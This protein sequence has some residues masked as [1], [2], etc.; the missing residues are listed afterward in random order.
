MSLVTDP[1]DLLLDKNNDLIVTTDLVFGRGVPAV[2]QSC[3]IVL[4]MFQGEWFLDQSAGIPYWQ[5][6][7][8]QKPNVA[9]A[10]MR[11][12]FSAALLAVEDV[13]SVLSMNVTYEGTTRTLTSSWAVSTAFGDST[14]QTTNIVVGQ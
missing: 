13:S 8:A 3:R 11:V 9:I 14:T 4:Q 2:V 6:I 7:L 5:S 12:A 1:R 10:A